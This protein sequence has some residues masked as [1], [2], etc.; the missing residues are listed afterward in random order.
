MS[1]RIFFTTMG[2]TRVACLTL[3]V[4][5][6]FV[7][8]AIVFGNAS[9]SVAQE[10]NK[11]EEPWH[12]AA[13]FAVSEGGKKEKA[14]ITLVKVEKADFQTGVEEGLRFHLCLAVDVQK[15]NK[16]AVRRY[17]RTTVFRDDKIND[18]TMAYSLKSWALSKTLPPNCH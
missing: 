9:T 7:G 18:Q 8:S 3:S 4:F 10:G 17:A 1:L 2:M 14:T 11:Y 6:L 12:P 15:G 13:R 5:A 16:K